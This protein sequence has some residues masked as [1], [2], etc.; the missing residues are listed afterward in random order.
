VLN[1]ADQAPAAITAHRRAL[2]VLR[3]AGRTDLEPEVLIDLGYT[4]WGSGALKA[5][6]EAL[7]TGR[8]ML[9]DQGRRDVRGWAH[10]TAGLGMVEQDAGRLDEAVAHQ[11]AA[12]EAF[13][14]ISGADHPDTAQA[15]DKLGYALRLQGR[16]DEAIETHR[17]GVRL[18]E[19]V[20]GPD[21]SRVA[22]AL[23]NL[24]LAVADSGAA[25]QAVAIQTRAREVFTAA[26]GP[27]HSSTLLAGDRLAHALVAAGQPVRAQAVR[28][29]VDGT[30]A[31][32]SMQ[33]E[34]LQR[35]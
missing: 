20:L 14:R 22:M 32:R 4:L 12:I 29:E 17:R 11:Q 26:L 5:A 19:R 13:T 10:A 7:R 1:C 31:D 23:T 15:L 21:D 24:G 3:R 6:G 35:S 2:D 27:T 9:E 18:L 34:S 25:D 33:E 8:A 16:V 30:T 28:D